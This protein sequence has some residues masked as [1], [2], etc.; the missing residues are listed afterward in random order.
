MLVH[1]TLMAV[2][3]ESL[4]ELFVEANKLS[5]H[6][7]D[8]V[9]PQLKQLTISVGSY[10]EVSISISAPLLEKVSWRWCH[11]R[12]IIKFGCWTLQKLRLQTAEGQGKLP[13]LHI[14]ACHVCL[15]SCSIYWGFQLI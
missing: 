10:M 9:T 1:D 15:D 13:S 3:S 5:A 11:L 12:N 4:Q 8:I 7:V 6:S 14:H 2:H